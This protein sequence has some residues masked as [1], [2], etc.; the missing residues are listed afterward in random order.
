MILG[1]TILLKVSKMTKTKV[2]NRRKGKEFDV[3][4]GRAKKGEEERKHMLNTEV[5]NKGWL[6]NPFILE[7]HG[8]DYTR[9]ESIKK[10]KEKFY[11]KLKN[12]PEFKQAVKQLKG[13]VLGGWCKPKACHGDVIVEYLEEKEFD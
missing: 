8:G 11:E 1:L 13:K 9:E 5:G 4:I 12:D 7:K 6:G 2:V 10:F 3:D